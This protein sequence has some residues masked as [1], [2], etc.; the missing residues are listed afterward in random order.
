MSIRLM[1]LCTFGMIL[2]LIGHAQQN[3]ELPA[4]PWAF[5]LGA[6]AWSNTWT[7]W[8]ITR[9]Q[10]GASSLQAI[11][12]V[13]SSHEV[14]FIP[15]ASLRYRR[16]F[17]SAS[18][19]TDTDYMLESSL[20]TRPG[21]RSESDVNL[22]FDV[23]S[24]LALTAGYKE[25]TQNVGGEYRWRGPTVA[26]SASAPLQSGFSVYG[27]YGAGWMTATLPAPDA[28]G[29]TSLDANYSVSEFG[30]AYSLARGQGASWLTLTL[31]YRSQTVRTRDYAL[32]SQPSGAVYA[33]DDTRDFTQGF[34]FSVIGAF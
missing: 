30:V 31:G 7:S 14:S 13:S 1:S 12:P 18:A 6:K 4:S 28:S 8:E 32:A 16:A 2:P 19:M 24:G 33:K 22:G 17:L 21:T 20:V 10:S 5:S 9:V 34:T 27:T 23:L 25:L 26:V 29:T 11:T 15:L 3:E